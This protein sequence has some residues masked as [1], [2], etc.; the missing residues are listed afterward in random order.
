[1]NKRIKRLHKQ[2]K[3]IQKEKENNS[4]TKVEYN[5]ILSFR[6]PAELKT[7]FFNSCNK[8]LVTPRKY[9]SGNV[10]RQFV[11]CYVQDSTF[12]ENIFASFENGTH[13][14]SQNAQRF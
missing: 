6:L 4:Y 12:F 11:Y 9:V 1:M 3:N 7:D 10:L 13:H 2:Y 8:N 14:T 5:A